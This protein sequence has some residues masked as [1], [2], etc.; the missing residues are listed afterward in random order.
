MGAIWADRILTWFWYYEKK[1]KGEEEEEEEEEGEEGEEKKTWK[2]DVSNIK[3]WTLM[4][5][6]D[7]LLAV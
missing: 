4:G 7:S 3:I 5:W 6:G 1:K 2:L